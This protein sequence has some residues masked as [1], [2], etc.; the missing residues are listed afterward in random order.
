MQIYF[1]FLLITLNVPPLIGKR[2]TGGTPDLAKTLLPNRCI[3]NHYAL[4]QTLL[5]KHLTFYR[6]WKLIL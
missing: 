5:A 6:S 2:T 1:A 4:H 3:V